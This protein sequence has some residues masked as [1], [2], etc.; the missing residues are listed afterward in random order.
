MSGQ[1]DYFAKRERAKVKAGQRFSVLIEYV[2]RDRGNVQSE[3]RRMAW[4]KASGIARSFETRQG[5]VSCVIWDHKFN[6][7]A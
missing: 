5:V 3:T 2:T 1:K 4:R 7:P 6:R